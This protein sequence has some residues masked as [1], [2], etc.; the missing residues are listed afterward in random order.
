MFESYNSKMCYEQA[1]LET[2]QDRINELAK[3][4]ILRRD[5]CYICLFAK[6]VK[7]APKKELVEALIK[8][9]NPIYL[10]EYAIDNEDAPLTRFAGVIIASGKIEYIKMFRDVVK[11]AP[12]D[13][14]NQALKELENSNLINL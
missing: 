9:Q 8:T 1:L 5:A 13:M 6:N 2:D 10:T 14:L 3:N 11:N 4:V 12:I 7:N